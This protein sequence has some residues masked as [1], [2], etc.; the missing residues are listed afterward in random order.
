MYKSEANGRKSQ[1]YDQHNPHRKVWLTERC[2]VGNFRSD[3]IL[4]EDDHY[5]ILNNSDAAIK[6]LTRLQNPFKLGWIIFLYKR[7]KPVC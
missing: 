7:L 3:S 2:T 6:S 1:L 4:N 5:K